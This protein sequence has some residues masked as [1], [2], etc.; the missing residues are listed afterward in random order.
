MAYADIIAHAFATLFVVIDPIGLAP[1]FVSLTAGSDSSS[2][3]LIAR[4]ATL[5]GA[6]ILIMFALLGKQLL[7]WM[8][9]T[10]PAFQIAG[11]IML[12]MLALEMLFERRTE[13]RNRSVSESHTE[14]DQHSPDDISVFPLATPLIAGP[15]AAATI[16]LLMGRHPADY[17]AQALII[18]V[19]IGVLI[20]TYILFRL[21][22][23]F[24]RLL[25]ETGIKVITRLLGVIL[26]AL[27]V[28]F[29]LSGLADAGFTA[30]I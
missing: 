27:A 8:G 21:A 25:G 18:G 11:G 29:V 4:R 10:L 28:Q 22:G 3:N 6:G 1:I 15:G 17:T 7:I 30:K 19:M 20:L 12:F 9:I 16:I 2:R 24:E 14:P 23:P 13:R 26:G 5:I